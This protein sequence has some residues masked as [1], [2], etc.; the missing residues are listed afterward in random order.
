[1]LDEG[2]RG[3]SSSDSAG[4]SSVAQLR[5]ILSATSGQGS[6][7]LNRARAS[8]SRFLSGSSLNDGTT[9]PR[10]E[11]RSNRGTVERSQTAID[12]PVL[13]TSPYNSEDRRKSEP[14]A[15]N[16]QRRNSSIAT[17]TLTPIDKSQSPLRRL[18]RRI[19][20]IGPSSPTTSVVDLA[21]SSM[22]TLWT[23]HNRL[24]SVD[25]HTADDTDKSKSKFT[26]N[27]AQ[28]TK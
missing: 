18:S 1:M 5:R 2:T 17:T 24:K 7:V 15:F 6:I 12:F 27:E 13:S 3:L 25:E 23:D 28:L 11:A 9:S 26:T 10:R 21:N 14:N 4:L 16:I 22:S 20:M 19:S 8:G